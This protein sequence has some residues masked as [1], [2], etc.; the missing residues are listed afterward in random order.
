MSEN[1]SAQ[2][3]DLKNWMRDLPEQIRNIPFIYLA[4][5]GNYI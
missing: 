5:P 1:G 3:V 2:R 4:I